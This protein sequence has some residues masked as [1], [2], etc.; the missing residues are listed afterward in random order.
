MRTN[1]EQ[2]L[3]KWRLKRVINSVKTQNRIAKLFQGSFPS[4]SETV[5]EEAPAPAP[6]EST[7]QRESGASGGACSRDSDPPTPKKS[8]VGRIQRALHLGASPKS[9]A[10]EGGKV[11]PASLRPPYAREPSRSRSSSTVRQGS[12]G[13]ELDFNNSNSIEES[14]E[15][16]STMRLSI[17]AKDNAPATNEP[18]ESPRAA[19]AG[20]LPAT[21]TPPELFELDA[22]GATPL[23]HESIS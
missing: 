12:G 19:A 16:L 3:R 10:I 23:H 2:R 4:N 15:R 7:E 14:L 17:G 22:C 5:A 1:M 8:V 6:A 20:V 18:P 13:D 21:E 9:T 11:S